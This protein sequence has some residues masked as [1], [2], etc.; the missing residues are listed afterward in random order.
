MRSRL[1]F[2][3]ALGAAAAVWVASDALAW[4]ARAVLVTLLVALPVLAVAQAE[5]I[6]PEALVL[7][8][9][10]V[11][12]S[13]AATLWL[14]GLAVLGVA[15]WSGFDLASL[16]LVPLA[17]AELV[18]WTLAGLFG[19]LALAAVWRVLGIRE[20]A[21]LQ[22]L[23][24][25][26]T[27]ERLAFVGLSLSAGLI[28]ELV[29]RGF[30][31]AALGVATGQLWLAVVLASIDFGVLH[32]YQGVAGAARAGVLGLFF[33]LPLLATGSVIP[34]M[35]AHFLYDLVAGLWLADWLTRR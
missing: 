28:E 11:Y 8:R 22:R 1:G 14:L 25:R 6:G 35:L 18:A 7:P 31:I 29:F 3:A 5:M 21:F 24:P 27:P 4:P 12:L 26:T 2:L 9:I 19:T 33:T 10:A 23:F 32:A 16:G 15:L 34:S 30:L 17:P 13:S 20:T